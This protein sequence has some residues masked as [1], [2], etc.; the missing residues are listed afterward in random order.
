MKR[1]TM[2]KVY[3]VRGSEDGNLG[4]YSNFKAAYEAGKAYQG[5]K[6]Y[7]LSY[8]QALKEIRE[9]KLVYLD[10][11]RELFGHAY[12]EAFDLESKA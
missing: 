3:L 5:N 12:I 11:N 7:T 2:K 1:H 10:D 6:Q 9:S 4:I 8:S